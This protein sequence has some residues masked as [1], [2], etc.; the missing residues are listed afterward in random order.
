MQPLIH[1]R[2]YPCQNLLRFAFPTINSTVLGPWVNAGLASEATKPG[3]SIELGWGAKQVNAFLRL[4][5]P[6]LFGHF[7]STIPGF[8]SIPN[9]PDS[10]GLRKLDYQL[11]YALLEKNRKAYRLVDETHPTA[12]TYQEH[13]T[14]GKTKATGYKAKT[15]YLGACSPPNPPPHKRTNE[16]PKL[17]ELQSHR[18]SS[19]N[20]FLPPL[21]RWSQSTP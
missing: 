4:H 6:A 1:L 2:R 17:P 20:G 5:F 15:L 18:G 14:S 3:F 21:H 7:D 16:S 9:E 8:Q 12:E 19:T 10:T 11:P 13:L